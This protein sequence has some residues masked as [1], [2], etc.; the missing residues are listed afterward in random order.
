MK[1]ANYRQRLIDEVMGLTG[2]SHI[3]S[4]RIVAA[5]F[6]CLIDHLR[7]GDTVT[8]RGVGTW[9]PFHLKPNRFGFSRYHI[10][11]ARTTIKFTP[12]VRIVEAINKDVPAC[13]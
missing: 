1:R 6:D 13:R 5:I 3:K 7:Q 9:Y 12:F 11:P 4:R 2:F 8:V 10:T